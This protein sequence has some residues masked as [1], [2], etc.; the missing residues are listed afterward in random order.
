MRVFLFIIA[1]TLAWGNSARAAPRTVFVQLFEWPWADI[2]RECE[3]Y[4]GPRGF[5]AVQ[6][7]PPQEHLSRAEA[8]WWERYQVVSYQLKSRSGDEAAFADMVRRCHK[9]GVDIY[10]DAVLNHMTGFIDGHGFAGTPFT[11]F[12]YPG[13][14][15]YDDFHHCG[16]NG[17]DIIKN[18]QDRYELQNCMLVDLADLKTE[19]D[20]V[21]SFLAAYL[22]HLLDL[23]VAGFRI[24]GAKHIP[25]ADIN[26]ILK[27]LKKSA[28]IYQE[29]IIS[30]GDPV[31]ADEYLINGDVM[32]YS[33]PY[34]VGKAL[35]QSQASALFTLADKLPAS[36]NAVVFISNHD[37]ERAEDQSQLL[38]LKSDATLYRL[39][40]IFMLTWPYGYPHIYSS[41]DFTDKDAGPPMDRN[42]MTTS[43]FDAR[44]NCQ[45]PWKC[46]HRLPEV[47]A[48]VDF[49]NLTDTHFTATDLWSNGSDQIAFGRSSAGFVVLNFSARTLTRSFP[50]S[51]PD[52]EYC[53]LIAT[54]YDIEHRSCARGLRVDV[55]GNLNITLAA[56]SAAVILQQAKVTSQWRKK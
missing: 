56:K 39:G 26:G 52:G 28:Y 12:G 22:N 24:D 4:L 27:R 6:V 9:A 47:A 51:L 44:G 31:T 13:L 43:V 38:S 8:N 45:A 7:S 29:L 11:H 16:R 1:L 23:G 41:F 10:V 40:Q 35:K 36:D 5:S 37:L 18:F 17:N 48:L 46:V 20:S 53:N 15:N 42:L 3:T 55:H 14:Y 34:L 54:D 25:A 32:A 49:R 50:T 19:S 33:Y 30:A 2:A 21:Q